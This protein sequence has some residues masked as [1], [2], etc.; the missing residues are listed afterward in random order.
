M[1][2]GV[3]AREQVADR[4]LA[5][6]GDRGG[7]GSD[8]E[9]PLGRPRRR[10]GIGGAGAAQREAAAREL[11][12]FEEREPALGELRAAQR[13]HR[14][15]GVVGGARLAPFVAPAA[16]VVLGVPQPRKRFVEPTG[17][18][19]RP[20]GEHRVGGRGRP[21]FP[22]AVAAAAIGESA[23]QVAAGEG[24]GIDPGALEGEDRAGDSRRCFRFRQGS[25][26]ESR[27]ACCRPWR[28]RAGCGRW[29][30]ARASPSS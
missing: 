2:V 15:A 25:S 5:A 27:R 21:P 23:D 19:G 28:C 18:A 8:R 20:Q 30:R 10:L 24:V 3:L 16:V 29:P 26:A 12:R 9:H 7:I 11:R 1:A 6:V 22:G 4:R 14:R 17:V 13:L